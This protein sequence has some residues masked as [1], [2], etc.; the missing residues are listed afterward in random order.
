MVESSLLLMKALACLHFQPVRPE[1]VLLRVQVS[2]KANVQWSSSS[3][4]IPSSTPPQFTP[5]VYRPG[6]N[7]TRAR[8]FSVGGHRSSRASR[9]PPDAPRARFVRR[10]IP[11][12]EG[13]L[14]LHSRLA[15]V[16]SRLALANT[17]V[18]ATSHHHLRCRNCSHADLTSGPASGARCG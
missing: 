13:D 4:S 2:S 7:G 12:V 15:C 14:P 17:S 5:R 11:C 3:A 9:Q 8:S 16:H 10:A 1:R 18:T 6:M